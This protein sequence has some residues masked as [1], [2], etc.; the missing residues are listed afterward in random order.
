MRTLAKGLTLMA[1]R[2]P[3]ANRPIKARGKEDSVEI[4]D[5]TKTEEVSGDANEPSEK[6]SQEEKITSDGMIIPFSFSA[7][8]LL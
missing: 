7:S 8:F 2:V 4:R 3:Q 6:R 1:G 5:G